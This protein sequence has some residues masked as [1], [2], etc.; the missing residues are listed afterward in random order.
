MNARFQMLKL[1]Q[2]GVFPVKFWKVATAGTKDELKNR[3]TEEFFELL[4]KLF[5]FYS[6]NH[7][8]QIHERVNV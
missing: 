1:I 6:M 8:Y 3:K 4:L 2:K 7:V 5:H